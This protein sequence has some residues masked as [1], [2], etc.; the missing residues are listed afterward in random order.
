M[1]RMKKGGVWILCLIVLASASL[2]AQGKTEA[3]AGQGTVV[4]TPVGTY[5]VVTKPVSLSFLTM[6]PVY[7]EDFTT[8]RFAQYLEDKTGVDIKWET[9]PRDAVKEKLN[10]ILASGDYP[11]VFFG[12]GRQ[13]QG[14]GASQ[15]MTYGVQEGMFLPLNDLID[16]YMPNL[17]K[18]LDE[19]PGIR[20]FLTSPDGNIYSLPDFNE[21]YHC[22]V[23]QKV[24]VYQPWLDAL[25]LKMPTTTDE[26]Y[27]MLVAFRDKDPNGNGKKDEIPYAGA[28]SGWN[29]TPETFLLNSFIYS[30]LVASLDASPSSAIGFYRDGN[31]IRTMVNTPEYRDSLSYMAKLY[32]EGLIY[33][34]SYTQNS[35]QLTQ[36]VEGPKEPIVG[37]VAGGYGGMFSIVGGERYQNFRLLA[38]LKGPSGA[39]YARFFT[40][41]P[42]IGNVVIS[43]TC[44]NPEVVAR[45][46]D[47][48]YSDEGTLMSNYGFEGEG[49]EWAKD[50]DVGL[51]GKKAIYKLLKAWNDMD[52]Q[53]DCFVMLGVRE[54]TSTIRNGEA[55]NPDVNLY[56]SEGLEALL[57]QKSAELYSPYAHPELEIPTLRFLDDEE[58][59]FA[60]K[61]VAYANYVRQSLVKFVTGAWSV[62]SDWNQYIQGLDKLDL[63]GI[64]GINQKAYNRQNGSN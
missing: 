38:P 34:A 37:V 61:K 51:D 53:N 58:T 25:G 44:K 16:T 27:Q 36:L 21:C 29:N 7:I 46:V 9:I 39:Q 4:V 52:P 2:W 33:A 22:T 47:Y 64:L 11:D 59:A 32:R 5:P 26:F 1:N 54:N 14:I 45:L 18:L 10:I 42:V 15:E 57:Y 40:Q 30:N 60:S 3:A 12:L 50:G 20:Q 43:K 23:S 13:E 6:Q 8:N 63:N 35:D 55:V 56:S 48:L 49:W 17:S 62:D 19:R 28:I 31:T 41:E 24:W